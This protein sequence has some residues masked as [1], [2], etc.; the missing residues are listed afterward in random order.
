MNSF[1]REIIYKISQ[2][3][4]RNKHFSSLVPSHLVQNHNY[5]NLKFDCSHRINLSTSGSSYRPE[6]KSYFRLPLLFF[7]EFHFNNS[8]IRNSFSKRSYSKSKERGEK[9]I[10]K[11]C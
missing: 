11:T 7:F 8:L 4:V 5:A 10:N 3:A 9:S 6:E 2:N 1:S